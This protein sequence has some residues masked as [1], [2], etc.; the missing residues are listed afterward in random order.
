MDT[1]TYFAAVPLPKSRD[2]IRAIDGKQA[3]GYLRASTDSV[4]QELGLEAQRSAIETWAA[5]EGARIIAWHCD[6][7]SGAAEIAKRPGLVAALND[8]AAKH[9]QY[10]TV[11]RVD[12][13]SRDVA[14]GAMIVRQLERVGAQLAVADGA[15]DGSDASSALVRSILFAVGQFERELIGSRIRV[16]LD[17][18]RARNEVTGRP[19]FGYRVSEDGVHVEPDGDEQSIIRSVREL[20]SRG[21]SLRAIA[22][23]LAKQGSVGRA[24]RPLTRTAIHRLVTRWARNE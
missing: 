5:R 18:K 12:R 24:G 23:E 9:A 15:G 11:A 4:R 10:L 7:M 14:I 6:E 17:V 8:I 1:K 16:A 2:A 20:Q 19:R 22:N 13:L 3:I 21:L